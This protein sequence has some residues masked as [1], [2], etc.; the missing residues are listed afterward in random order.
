MVSLFALGMQT[1]FG[2]LIIIAPLSS[3]FVVAWN[4][5]S[6]GSNAKELRRIEERSATPVNG[7][8]KTQDTKTQ[9][10]PKDWRR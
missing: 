1:P 3:L 9:V 8:S 7:S 6:I 10:L 4:R 5:P 2:W